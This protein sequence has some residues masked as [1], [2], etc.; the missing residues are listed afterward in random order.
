MDI[1]THKI[2]LLVKKEKGHHL[3][4]TDEDFFDMLSGSSVE[5]KLRSMMSQK[6][7]AHEFSEWIKKENVKIKANNTSEV[8][9][10]FSLPIQESL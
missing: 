5:T 3:A 2:T 9:L 10:L 1:I 8:L 6:A 7:I 4:D